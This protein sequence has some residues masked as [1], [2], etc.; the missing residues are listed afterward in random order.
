MSKVEISLISGGTYPINLY[1][2][3]V[4][5]N[6]K[7]FV[8][9]I[10]SG[11]VPPVLDFINLPVIFNTAPAVMV[12]MVD[13]NLCEKF[14]IVQ[15][16]QLPPI[17]PSVTPTVTSTNITPTPTPTVT[18]TPG[19]SPTPTTTPTPT[20]TSTSSNLGA[21]IFMESGD[22]CTGTGPE[23]TDLLTYMIN[24]GSGAWFTFHSDGIPILTDPAK[25][26]DFLVYLDWPGFVTGTA[27]VPSTIKT[28]VPQS[29]GGYDSFGNAIEAYKFVTTEV[30]G[31]STTGNVQYVILAP[32]SLTNNKVYSSVGIS[33]N[34][35]PLT[36]IDTLTD[37]NL[38]SVNIVYTGGN[39]PQ[40]TYKV[41]SQ[42]PSNG[43]DTGNDG[44]TDS[45]NNYFRGGTLT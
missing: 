38:R 8:S 24:N 40:T 7:T 13:A 39:W 18:K 28:P 16:Q 12:T 10:T 42:S 23:N 33:Y 25:L 34:N 29:S 21:L 45:T 30:T 20:V 26:S 22:D 4:Y 32:N 31:G 27:N 36:L 11:P 15:C 3:D 37:T 44:I 19:Q 35:S 6:N 2:S 1:V 41:Y 43:F 5:G 9:T 17:T 14:E